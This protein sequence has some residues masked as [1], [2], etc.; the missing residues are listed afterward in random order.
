MSTKLQALVS[1]RV[2]ER[3]DEG[4]DAARSVWNAMVDRRPRYIVRCRG[5]SDVIA[6]VRFATDHALEIG[7]RCGGHGIVGHAVPDDGLMIDLRPM[8]GV[9]VDAER[10]TAHVQGGALLGALDLAA[11]QHGL[12]TTAG[13][14][15]H[16]GV[17]GLT[18]GGGMGWLAR[19]H[20]L[21]CDNV[22]AFEVVTAAGEVLRA[23]AESHPDLYWGLRGG[24]GNFG[25]VTEFEFALHSEPGNAISAELHYPPR[26]ARDAMRQWR[27]LAP[28]A[29]RQA[30]MTAI[31]GETVS[32]GLVWVGDP[33]QGAAYIDDIAA[34]IS[35]VSEPIARDIAP[36]AYLELQTRNDDTEEH[37]W[38]RYWKGHYFAELGDDAIDA[39]LARDGDEPLNAEIQAYGGAIADVGDAE[40]AFS[41]RETAFEFV[42][43]TKW[44]DPA[45]DDQRIAAARAYA[46]PLAPFASGAYVNALTDEGDAGL[47]RAYTEHKLARLI[48]V[49]DAYDPANVFHLNQNIRPTDTRASREG[50]S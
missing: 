41:H 18:L 16:T 19:Q 3:G 20:G 4:Y 23:S 10:R 31:L 7:I 15:S 44:T 26:R 36:L 30:T 1:G 34:A 33:A 46:A 14:V 35:A 32:L 21:A 27:D 9:R 25:V 28:D 6:A 37:A 45:D 48:A 2:L 47:N 38:R 39:V 17:G 11:Q 42:A 40:T 50:T 5:T 43:A 12:A 8:D 22:V 49:K 29:P 24:G 13:N